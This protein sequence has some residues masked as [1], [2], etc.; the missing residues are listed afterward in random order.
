MANYRRRLREASGET[1]ARAAAARRNS[2]RG[3]PF[4]EPRKKSCLYTA[5]LH[6]MPMQRSDVLLYL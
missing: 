6:I 2:S 3:I 1:L 5:I 4:T